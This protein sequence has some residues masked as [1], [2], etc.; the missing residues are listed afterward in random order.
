[1]PAWATSNIFQ[2]SA[3]WVLGGLAASNVVPAGMTATGFLG[4]TMNFALYGATTAPD[5]TVATAVLCSYNG[6]ASQWITGAGYEVANSGTYAAGGQALAGKAWAIDATAGPCF[7]AT[8]PSWTGATI[9]AYGGLLYDSTITTSG[10]FNAKQ[11]VCFNYFGGV[12][13]V[14]AGTFTV[15]YATAGATANTIFNIAV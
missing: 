11:G 7:S 2:Y 13:T 14:T 4:D 3:K 8:G 12:Q 6:A 10:N 1:M 15:V 9:T 5:K